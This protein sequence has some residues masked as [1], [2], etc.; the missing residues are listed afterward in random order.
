MRRF[1]RGETRI[2]A[3]VGEKFAVELEAVPTA[4]YQWRL[5][6][7]SGATP[8]ALRSEEHAAASRA[9]GGSSTQS[10]VL[11][12][13]E[14]GHT[15]LEFVYGRPWEQRPLER[16]TVEIEITGPKPASQRSRGSRR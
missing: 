15:T 7:P 1:G 12:A 10:F 6:M 2:D 9:V 8:I 5:D 11:E 3:R 13:R 4:G 14:P 16:H